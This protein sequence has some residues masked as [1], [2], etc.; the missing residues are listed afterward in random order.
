MKRRPG[1]TDAEPQDILD[2]WARAQVNQVMKAGLMLPYPD[3]SFQPQTPMTRAGFAYV[4]QEVLARVLADGQLST[5]YVN[6]SSP[7]NDVPAGHFAYNAIMVCTRR[8]I[9][10]PRVDG[11]FGLKDPIPGADAIVM[12]NALRDQIP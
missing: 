10:K 7:F 6:E 5:R 12:I 2:Y 8:G 1:S 3:G 11:S 4:A 9:M